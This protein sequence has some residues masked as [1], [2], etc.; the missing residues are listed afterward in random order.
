M[1]A[2]PASGNDDLCSGIFRHDDA[3]GQAD[4]GGNKDDEKG[5]HGGK[6]WENSMP[7]T[8]VALF[9]PVNRSY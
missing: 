8:L 9:L 6:R 7:A 1:P 4:N 2:M 5:S 3:A